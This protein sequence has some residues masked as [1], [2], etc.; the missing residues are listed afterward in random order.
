[1]FIALHKLGAKR[2]PQSTLFRSAQRNWDA[3]HS[4]SFD[5]ARIQQF[6]Q[7]YWRLSH[8]GQFSVLVFHYDSTIV[9][10]LESVYFSRF[11]EIIANARHRWTSSISLQSVISIASISLKSPASHGGRWTRKWR[12][13]NGV[14]ESNCMARYTSIPHQPNEFRCQLSASR[15]N[16]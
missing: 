5:W 16:K 15:I 9:P 6:N 2:A 7:R 13:A 11:L 12:D 4:M 10:V 1:M 3:R 14:K 8:V